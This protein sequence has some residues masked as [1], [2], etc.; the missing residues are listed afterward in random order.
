MINLRKF[1]ISLKI[2]FTFQ[3]VGS[4]PKFSSIIAINPRTPI[5]AKFASYVPMDAVDTTNSKVI[6]EI[7]NVEIL[8][9][10]LNLPR[11]LEYDVLFARITPS[12]EN[13]KTSLIENQDLMM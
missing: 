8:S 2:I 7:L 3:I 12:T 13:G 6:M 4:Y 10:H 5:N 9:S 11:F 1:I